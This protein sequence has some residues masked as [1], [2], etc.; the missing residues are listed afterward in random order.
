MFGAG[1]VR[2]RSSC[3]ILLFRQS[4]RVFASSFGHGW[5]FLEGDSFESDF[6]LRV[7]INALDDKKL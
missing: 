3:A 2:N 5:M 1:P 4:G 7:A 6:G